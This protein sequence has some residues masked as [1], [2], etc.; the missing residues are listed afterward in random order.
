MKYKHL[1]NHLNKNK[2]AIWYY[3]EL[4]LFLFWILDV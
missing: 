3:A 2:E 1:K 4:L